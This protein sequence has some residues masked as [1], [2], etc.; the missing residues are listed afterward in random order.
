MRNSLKIRA[1]RSGGIS[2]AALGIS[3]AS[4]LLCVPATASTAFPTNKTTSGQSGA[5]PARHSLPLKG[6]DLLQHAA[7]IDGVDGNPD[8]VI[9]QS[10]Y[11]QA[12]AY[13]L[14]RISATPS[15]RD[16][17]WQPDFSALSA[18]KSSISE[19]RQHLRQMLGW[20]ELKPQEL[21]SGS[22]RKA[23]ASRSKKSRLNSMGISEREHCCFFPNPPGGVERRL[24]FPGQ[25]SRRKPSQESPKGW[26][27]RPIG[28]KP[29][30][31]GEWRWP[32]RKCW[33]GSQTIP[34]A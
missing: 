4:N 14:Q 1:R 29:F 9:D 12:E 27:P 19:H 30:W 8:Y 3:L 25:I 32:F 15:L 23:P 20:I 18:Y 31:H 6:T 26:R 34:Y 13:F 17:L 16:K 11:D 28:C 33:S 2:V 22:F 21:K 10:Q 24:R 5:A 7:N